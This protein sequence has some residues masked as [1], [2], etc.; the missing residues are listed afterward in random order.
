MR[1]VRHGHSVGLNNWFKNVAMK[2][3]DPL[4]IVGFDGENEGK[5]K[6]ALESFYYRPQ[7]S[8][9]QGNILHLSAILFGG[10]LPQCMLGCHPPPRRPPAKDIPL[11]RRPPEGGTHPLPRRPPPAKETPP[12]GGTPMPRRPPQQWDPPPGIWLMSS[13]YA[14]YWNAFLFILMRFAENNRPKN[15]L[16]PPVGWRPLVR[17]ISNQILATGYYIAMLPF[18]FNNNL[19]GEIHLLHWIITRHFSLSL[20]FSVNQPW[21][22]TTGR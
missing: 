8:C 21:I 1:E 5:G 22:Y 11:P 15:R 16:T 10:G 9:G 13:W 4:L 12:E 18:G 7:R 2:N 20:T 17:E 6:L 19:N 14:S 3:E